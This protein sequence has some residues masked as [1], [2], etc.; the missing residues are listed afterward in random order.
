MK[1]KAGKR[2][3]VSNVGKLLKTKRICAHFICLTKKLIMKTN[4]KTFYITSHRIFS[5]KKKKTEPVYVSCIPFLFRSDND[6]DDGEDH[7]VFF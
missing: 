2:L 7:V 1:V 4:D 5:F 6:D 3:Y